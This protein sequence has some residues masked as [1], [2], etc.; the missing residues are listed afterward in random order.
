MRGDA[1]NA[2]AQPYYMR[3][4]VSGIGARVPVRVRAYLDDVADVMGFA[5]HIFEEKVK[6]RE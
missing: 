4:D 6:A 5:W 3:L 2:V 1:E